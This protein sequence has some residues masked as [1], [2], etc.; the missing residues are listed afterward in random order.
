MRRWIFSGACL[1]LLLPPSGVRSA[2]APEADK[3]I[4]AVVARAVEARGGSALIDKYRARVGKFTATFY[5]DDVQIITNATSRAQEPDKSRVEGTMKY[6][7]EEYTIIQVVNGDKGWNSVNGNV[8]AMSAEEVA[9]MREEMYAGGLSNLRG[10]TAKGVKLTALGGSTV[11]GKPAVGIRVSAEGHRD[12]SLY[13]DK[14]TGLLVKCTMRSKDT[15]SGEQFTEDILYSDYKNVSGLMI[16][17]RTVVN[18]DG[19]PYRVREWLEIS[20]SESLPQDA[21]NKP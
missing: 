8:N 3:E 17:F 12:V 16:P 20:V 13:F 19:K 10:L 14:G 2:P 18:R 5:I 21:F 6:P 4:K 11:Q 15:N 7:C 1:A 9:E